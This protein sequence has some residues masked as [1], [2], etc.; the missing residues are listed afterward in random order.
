MIESAVLEDLIDLKSNSSGLLSVKG[1]F[2]RLDSYADV[3]LNKFEKCENGFTLL[4]K[5]SFAY[6]NHDGTHLLISSG[7]DSS[8]TTGG[9]YLQQI[10]SASENYLEFGLG[11]QTRLYKSKV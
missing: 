7:G 10:K 1:I 8:Y 4:L 11:T 5:I 9:F 3:C 6:M 2:F